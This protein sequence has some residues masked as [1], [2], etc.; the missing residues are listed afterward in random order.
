MK[1]FLQVFEF[2]SYKYSYKKALT[3]A[4]GLTADGRGGVNHKTPFRNLR[5]AAAGC[6]SRLFFADS[7]YNAPN[8][9]ENN[10]FFCIF[11]RRFFFFSRAG[12]ILCNLRLK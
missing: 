9:A 7:I 1:F 2:S 5:R 6:K 10:H 11:F 8:R 3:R 4:A 12:E